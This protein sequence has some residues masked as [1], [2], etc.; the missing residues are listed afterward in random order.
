MSASSNW[1]DTEWLAGARS[2][3]EWARR[4]PRNE[5][6]MIFLRH[7]QRD[8]IEDHSAQFSTGLT[9]VGKQMSY[10]MGR[11]LPTDRPV[12]IFFSFVPRCHETAE[13]LAE[14]LS[15]SGGEIVEF[16]SIAILVMPEFSNEAVWENLQPDGKNVTEFVNRWAEGEFGEKIES[17]SEYEDRL[18]E[19][20]L[21][22]LRKDSG[23][24]V[25]I[26]MT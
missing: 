26:H 19:T 6:C 10:E 17:W 23:P 11:R 15:D 5:R 2:L 20:T 7:S 1:D 13:Q 14:G 3:V 18:M 22:R 8:V 4:R 21:Q 25:H 9:K 16:E 12:R 24:V